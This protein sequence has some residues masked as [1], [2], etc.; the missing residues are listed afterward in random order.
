[1]RANYSRVVPSEPICVRP[2]YKM[3]ENDMRSEASV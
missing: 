1:M 3:E 2:F